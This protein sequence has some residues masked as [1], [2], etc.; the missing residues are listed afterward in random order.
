MGILLGNHSKYL[1]NISLCCTITFMMS[2]PTKCQFYSTSIFTRIFGG[3]I[4]TDYPFFYSWVSKFVFTSIKFLLSMTF[5]WLSYFL[6]TNIKSLFINDLILIINDQ[7]EIIVLIVIK[8]IVLIIIVS[9]Q[10]DSLL[11][12]TTRYYHYYY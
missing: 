10:F 6:F 3:H 7:F 12:A 1:Y 9:F 11:G 5:S 2:K 8:V 4:C